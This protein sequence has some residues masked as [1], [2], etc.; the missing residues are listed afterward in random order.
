M[1]NCWVKQCRYGLT[2]L[3]LLQTCCLSC[4]SCTCDV[5]LQVVQPRATY[6]NDT[7]VGT[8]HV[9]ALS[10]WSSATS[11]VI[12]AVGPFANTIL[13]VCHTGSSGAAEAAS[14]AEKKLQQDRLA[15]LQ[16]VWKRRLADLKLCDKAAASPDAG[17]GVAC[18]SEKAD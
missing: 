6:L 3:W 12:C 9:L 15:R 18:S 5:L 11:L 13:H 8:P 7:V 4:V 16:P 14:T 17:C 10:R 1:Y 2:P